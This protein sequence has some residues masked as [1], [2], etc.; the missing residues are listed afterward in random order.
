MSWASAALAWCAKQT[1]F[2]LWDAALASS[3]DCDEENIDI[4]GNVSKL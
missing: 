1:L 3:R 4:L 2:Y